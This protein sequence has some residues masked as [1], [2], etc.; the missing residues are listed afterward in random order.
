MYQR[1]PYPGQYAGPQQPDPAVN[2]GRS[3]A[4]YYPPPQA[5]VQAGYNG[6]NGNAPQYAGITQQHN[7]GSQQY[8]SNVHQQ[9]VSAQQTSTNAARVNGSAHH[10]TGSVTS[11]SP[12][13]R[14]V[15]AFSPS[16]P[17]SQ[18]EQPPFWQQ[19]NSNNH[20]A[21][22]PSQQIPG[23]PWQQAQ[24]H[25]LQSRH[26]SAPSLYAANNFNLP[27]DDINDDSLPS[28]LSYVSK[29]ADNLETPY[30]GAECPYA[31]SH[32]EIDPDLCIGEV[33]YY[34]ALPT[35]RPLPATAKE[36]EVE[37]IAPRVPQ[38]TD[39]ESIS[40]YFINSRVENNLLDVR[41]T[42]MWGVVRADPLFRRFPAIPEDYIS[43]QQMRANWRDRPDPTYTEYI[44]SPSPEPEPEPRR[45]SIANNE[46]DALSNLEN[47]LEHSNDSLGQPSNP[48]T[49]RPRAVGDTVRNQT[50]EDILA[51]LGVTGSPKMVYQTPGPAYPRNNS[52]SSQ[53]GRPRESFSQSR[54]PP[55]PPVS[56]PNGHHHQS[57]DVWSEY[58]RAGLWD[59]RGHSRSRSASSAAHTNDP[60]RTPRAD[61]RG[62]NRKRGH[63]EGYDGGTGEGSGVENDTPRPN[64]KAPR[65]SK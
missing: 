31:H 1:P 15:S 49:G 38:P 43:P 27:L 44:P 9:Y 51:A 3:P 62:Q 13:V 46:P 17:F 32:Q 50:Q 12:T 48:S 37:A 8:N 20:H 53:S 65:I 21:T 64:R 4:A 59:L 14:P 24:S 58:G 54:P 34:P 33:I 2:Y 36:A 30:Y 60:E 18:S 45:P 57:R 6:Y 26:N 42:D 28:E 16:A 23:P 40:E 5:L 41:Q 25:S 29:E 61:L 22:Q 10:R 63:E 7:A 47:A 52:I 11:Y 35:I 56:P 39:H 55:P 19:Q